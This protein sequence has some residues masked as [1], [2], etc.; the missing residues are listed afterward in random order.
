MRFSVQWGKV[1]SQVFVMYQFNQSI[2]TFLIVGI[3]AAGSLCARLYGV[4]IESSY[5]VRGVVRRVDREQMQIIVS[6]EDIPGFMPAMTMPFYLQ[7]LEDVAGIEPGQTV[8]FTFHIAT[9]RSWSSDFHVLRDEPPADSAS[10]PRPQTS[11]NYERL[12]EGDP[13]IEFSMTD[14]NGEKF[15]N[16]DMRGAYTVLTFIYTRCPVPEFCPLITRQMSAIQDGLAGDQNLARHVRLLS[17]T[18]D[19][20]FD[21][22][23]ILKAYGEAMGSDF[24]LWT[25][26]VGAP[27]ETRRLVRAFSVYVE[28]N[29]ATIDHALCTALVGPDGKVLK[30]WRGNRW[31]PDEILDDLKARLAGQS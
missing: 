19:P 29:G 24:S 11:P 15:S 28:K 1:W 12:R 4:N 16:E 8:S 13:L 2:L 20:E 26:A 9:N 5:A 14:Q 25:Y 31:R 7:S 18:L 6:H 23:G 22:P 27:E 21:Q 3:L 10:P 17:I 30:I